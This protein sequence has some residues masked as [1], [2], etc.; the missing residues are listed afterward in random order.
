MKKTTLIPI[1]SGPTITRAYRLLEVS[2][3]HDSVSICLWSLD[4]VL[5]EVPH[6]R[7]KIIFLLSAMRHFAKQLE[8]NGWQV[9]YVALR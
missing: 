9:D 8:L 4:E 3:K 1:L 7:K 2:E 5:S 6:H